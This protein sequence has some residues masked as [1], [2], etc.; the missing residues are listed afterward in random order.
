MELPAK[1]KKLYQ[2]AS[3]VTSNAVFYGTLLFFVSRVFGFL[4]LFID[5]YNRKKLGQAPPE[6]FTVLGIIGSILVLGVIT[7]AFLLLVQY[8]QKKLHL[9]RGNFYLLL[10]VLFCCMGHNSGH[11][12]SGRDDPVFRVCIPAGL[13]NAAR[14]AGIAF[15]AASASDANRN[16]CRSRFCSMRA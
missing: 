15:G 4:Q 9:R 16:P 12:L 8:R 1:P 13:F 10:N 6:N 3:Y 14:R 5:A 2:S 11:Q 7:G